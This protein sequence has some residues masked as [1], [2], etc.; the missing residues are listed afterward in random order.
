[1]LSNG[2]L[3]ILPFAPLEFRVEVHTAAY[4]CMLT[5]VVGTVISRECKIRAGNYPLLTNY[6]HFLNIL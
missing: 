4:K 6:L 1:M 2:S 5:N 3:Y